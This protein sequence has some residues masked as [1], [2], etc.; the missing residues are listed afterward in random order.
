MI[1][2]TKERI[3]YKEFK[4]AI[5]NNQP[6]EVLTLREYWTQIG[7]HVYSWSKEKLKECYLN[8]NYRIKPEY[9]PFELTKDCLNDYKKLPS[10]Y[11]F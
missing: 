1:E 3:S 6:L 4:K 10:G 2:Y 8:S 9:P 11:L 7:D 5:K